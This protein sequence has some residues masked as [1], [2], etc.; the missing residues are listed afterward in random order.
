VNETVGRRIQRLAAAKGLPSGKA[1]AALL[2]VTYE[3]MRAWTADGAKIAPNRNRAAFIADRLG[4]SV[5]ELMFGQARPP[6][7]SPDAAALAEAFDQL[8]V[9]TD[10]AIDRR[11]RLYAVLLGM[12]SLHGASDSSE[13]EPPPAA[14][15]SALRPRGSKTPP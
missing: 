13:P 7:F 2:G 9:D 10:G 1:L 5:E 15:P 12:I 4:I 6:T 8:P 3:T 11:A 14:P